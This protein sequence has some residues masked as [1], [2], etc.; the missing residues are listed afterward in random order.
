[1]V[2]VL[3]TNLSNFFSNYLNFLQTIAQALNSTNI[4]VIT[5]ISLVSGS[6]NFTGNGT[7]TQQ[8]NS[9]GA[10]NQF[11]NLNNILSNGNS[12]AG[13]ELTS[14]QVDVN[15]GEVEEPSSGSNLALILGTTIPLA[16]LRKH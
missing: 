8:S 16:V 5:V 6:V 12:I 1:M 13:M 3:N 4:N 9:D 10:S 7:T 11:N 15:G 14:S 2:L